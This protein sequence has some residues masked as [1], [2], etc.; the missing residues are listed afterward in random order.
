MGRSSSRRVHI[1]DEA[2]GFTILLMILY[3]AWY[4]MGYMFNWEIGKKLFDFFKHDIPAQAFFAGVFI[5]ICGMSCNFSHSNVKR[6][7]KLAAAAAVISLV[8]WCGAFWGIVDRHSYIWFGILHC[9]A[10]CVLL[11]A[12][13]R[14]TFRLIPPIVGL[15]VSAVLLAFCWHVPFENGG[16]FGISGLFTV[17]VAPAAPNDPW[18]YAFGLCPVYGVADYFPLIPWFFCF[19]MGT[20]VGVWAKEGKF[21]QFCYRPHA[22]FLSKIGKYTLWIYALHQPVVYV[23]CLAVEA[24]LKLF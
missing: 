7:I 6:G 24:V 1:V 9:L 11:Y 13:L 20:F 14:P 3:H 8:M 4:I 21:P 19:L 22:P 17:P 10:V 18:L 23:L 2:R 16:Y 15:I 12:L 5:F